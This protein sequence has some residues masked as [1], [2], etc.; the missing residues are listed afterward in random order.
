MR[1]KTTNASTTCHALSIASDVI[2]HSSK[3]TS[4]D[5]AM[6]V[7]THTECASLLRLEGVALLSPAEEAPPGHSE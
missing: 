5:I 3:S 4:E 7:H 6:Y 2:T 1:S